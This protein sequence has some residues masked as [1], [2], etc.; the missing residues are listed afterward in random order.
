MSTLLIRDQ[1]EADFSAVHDL[2]ITAFKTL[3]IAC[4]REQF[5][6]DDLWRRRAA[7]VAL[8]AEEVSAYGR[9]LLVGQAAFSKITINGADLGWHGCG[10]LSV[11][12][13]RHGLGIGTALMRE[14]LNRLKTLGS[15]GCVVVGDPNYYLRFGFAHTRTLREPSVPPDAF[16]ALR[17]AGDMPSGEVALDSAFE[18]AGAN[19]SGL[20]I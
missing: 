9:H 7:T 20:P 5:V 14:G 15:K 16:M 11:L 3:P 18:V 2:V 6:M 19:A 1:T 12:P 17:F 10:P 4:G 13:A 8:I